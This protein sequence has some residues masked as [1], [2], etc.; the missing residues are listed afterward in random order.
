MPQVTRSAVSRSCIKRNSP[1]FASLWR[2]DQGRCSRID[3]MYCTP[4]LAPA[5]LSLEVFADKTVADVS[6]HALVMATFERTAFRRAL[7]PVR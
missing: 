4:D 5:L 6:D 1:G 7:T 2:K 3:R